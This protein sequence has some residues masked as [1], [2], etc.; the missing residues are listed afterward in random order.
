MLDVKKTL[1]KL[2]NGFTCDLLYSGSSTGNL[3]LSKAIN[4]YERLIFVYRDND[5]TKFTK[6]IITN[7]INSVAFCLDSLRVT[8]ATYHKN[9]IGV[10]NGATITKSFNRQSAGTATPTEGSYI[11]I[12]KVYGCKN[13]VGG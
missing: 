5:N 13:I 11:Y 10:I 12:E 6:E 3:T 4:N 8:G 9:Y 1:A 2:L 7:G